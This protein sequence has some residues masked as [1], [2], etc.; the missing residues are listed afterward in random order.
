[1]TPEQAEQ[2]ISILKSLDYELFVLVL[3]AGFVAGM[4]AARR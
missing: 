4:F 3:L 1:M 2:L